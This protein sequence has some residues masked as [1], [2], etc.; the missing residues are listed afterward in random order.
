MERVAYRLLP[1][2]E[3]VERAEEGDQLADNLSHPRLVEGTDALV[4]TGVVAGTLAGE[5]RKLSGIVDDQDSPRS[6]IGEHHVENGK[7]V[8]NEATLRRRPKRR[9]RTVLRRQLKVSLGS[10]HRDADGDE[11]VICISPNVQ[12]PQCKHSFAN[13]DRVMR[14]WTRIGILLLVLRLAWLCY[15]YHAD[16]FALMVQERLLLL[17]L[18]ISAMIFHPVR[19]Y[20][21]FARMIRRIRMYRTEVAYFKASPGSRDRPCDGDEVKVSGVPG[22]V[23]IADG[24]TP[25]VVTDREPDSFF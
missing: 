1:T 15:K 10:R 8:D 3:L 5:K 23:L 11:V 9:K 25:R 21:T 22:G 7:L 14:Y 4:V 24:D 18:V 19:T 2:T 20:R 16:I 6:S 13:G 17:T 12:F